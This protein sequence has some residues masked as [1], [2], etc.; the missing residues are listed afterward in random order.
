MMRRKMGSAES[1]RTFAKGAIPH[2]KNLRTAP[3]RGGWRL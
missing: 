2:S 1:R 3:Q